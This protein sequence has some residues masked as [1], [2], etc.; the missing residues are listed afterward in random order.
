[1]EVEIII[2][3]LATQAELQ[4]Y[5]TNATMKLETMICT[6]IAL[7]SLKKKEMRDW[8]GLR[9]SKKYSMELQETLAKI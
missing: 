2:L 7:K 9:R 1:M 5:Y 4:E 8:R 6:I 3:V